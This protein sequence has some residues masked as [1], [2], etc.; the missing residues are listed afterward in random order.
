MFLNIFFLKLATF[1][2]ALFSV[3]Y[4]LDFPC[5]WFVHLEQ[6]TKKFDEN[7]WLPSSVAFTT[8]E[9]EEN[10]VTDNDFIPDI[11]LWDP[12]VQFPHLAAVLTKCPDCAMSLERKQWQN[13]Q[14]PGM[15]PR[16]LH[17]VD[18]IV[19]LVSRTY[20]CATGHRFLSHDPQ[21]LERFSCASQIPF[22]LS[23][24]A[25]LTMRCLSVVR[26]LIAKGKSITTIEAVLKDSRKE[27]YYRK[28]LCAS[29]N[30]N[31]N[32]LPFEKTITGKLKA[33][34]ELLLSSFLSVFWKNE[35]FYR[36]RLHEVSINDDWICCDHTFKSAMN[37]GMY[38]QKTEKRTKWVKQFKALFLVLN[39]VGQ[40]LSWRLVEDT[41][42]D[43][44]TD[45]LG[46]IQR[47]LTKQEKELREIYVDDCCK[48]RKKLQ[49]IFGN[50]LIKLDIFHAVQRITK[51]VSK[52]HA[53]FYDFITSLKLVFRSSTDLGATRQQSTPD[54]STLEKNMNTFIKRWT[55]V[56]SDN[57]NP[58]LTTPV[59]K[60]INNLKVHI[61][62]G[63]LSYIKPGRGTNRDESLHRSLNS[64]MKYSKIGTELAY[65]LLTTTI[66]DNNE[67]RETRDKKSFLEYTTIKQMTNHADL[68][69]IY[70]ETPKFGLTNA[71]RNTNGNCDILEG[72]ADDIDEVL[73]D[74]QL[75]ELFHRAKQLYDAVETMK[76]KGVAKT[77]FNE[78]YIPFMNSAASLFS[79]GQFDQNPHGGVDDHRNRLNAVVQS[80]GFQLVNVEG[81]GNCFFYSVAMSLHHFLQDNIEDVTI[82]LGNL[83]I[84]ADSSNEDT[85]QRLR[86]L[87]VNEWVT[88][89][90][91]YQPFVGTNIQEEANLYLRSGHFMGGLGNLM[92]LAMANILGSP[93]IIFSSLETMPVILIT[94]AST[95]ALPTIHLAFNQFGAGHYDGVQIVQKEKKSTVPNTTTLKPVQTGGATQRCSCGKNS[96]RASTK[97]SCINSHGYASRCPCLKAKNG[98]HSGCA[99][100]TCDN[101]YG[102]NDK[103]NSD[104]PYILSSP[105]PR[106]RAKHTLSGTRTKAK[107]FMENMDAKIHQEWNSLEIIIFECLIEF[108]R[109]FQIVINAANLHKYFNKLVEKI[110][111][112]N[113][114]YRVDIVKKA[115]N[116]IKKRME[117]HDKALKAWLNA[118]YRKQME[119]NL[120]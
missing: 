3:S 118:Y 105:T 74:E 80:W 49:E 66:D 60:E 106:K 10:L 85:A 93:L 4:G 23:H 17:D 33:G 6:M 62:N 110:A 111:E 113:P 99:C 7:P 58:I 120:K 64:F 78:R 79:H 20:V 112:L 95:T 29:V 108:F 42:Y 30:P 61:R 100:K 65:A 63:C 18:S 103:Q 28:L 83:G 76:E 102:K 14:Q 38:Q 35:I 115:V 101:P 50:V 45:L 70:L 24:K 51:K 86:E 69:Q 119:E 31:M 11:I 89:Q 109:N 25:G 73:T 27:A 32:F 75:T 13:K 90:E 77:I 71:K 92:P 94:P 104:N 97:Q 26:T 37:I 107:E 88:N 72:N 55:G 47:R 16:L 22:A 114:K 98:C 8:I 41:S 82:H 91:R 68:E 39:D 36:R 116:E 12:I 117:A 87:V 40:T 34:S 84:T 19:L 59:M 54:P 67:R 15:Q 1:L 81:D 56:N 9:T 96:K 48:S 2:L 21:V 44:V 57:G 53:L 46:E 5:H 52:R 43:S